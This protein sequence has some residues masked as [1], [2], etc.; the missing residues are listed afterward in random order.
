MGRFP[1]PG[2]VFGVSGRVGKSAGRGAGEAFKIACL[3]RFLAI[4]ENLISKILIFKEIL[5]KK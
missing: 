5:K 3:G 4:F 2:A 1:A